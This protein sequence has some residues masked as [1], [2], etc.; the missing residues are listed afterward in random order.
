MNIEYILILVSYFLF[1][2]KELKIYYNEDLLIN[3]F[4]IRYFL[5]CLKV[6]VKIMIIYLRRSDLFDQYARLYPLILIKDLVNM[7]FMRDSWIAFNSKFFTCKVD[8]Q[9]LF[10]KFDRR[11]GNFLEFS[12]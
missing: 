2:L 8:N 11:H 9:R 6:V 1:C 10:C 7:A 12:S 4:L 5:F 3:K